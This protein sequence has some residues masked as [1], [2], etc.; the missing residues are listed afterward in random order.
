MENVKNWFSNPELIMTFVIKYGGQ[1]LFAIITLIIGLWIISLLMKGMK[2]MFIARDVE[3]GLQSFLLSVS[4]I[5][6][7]IM[8]FISVISMLGIRMTS[9]IAVLGAAGLAIGMALSGSLQN[10][11]GGVMILIFKPFKVGDYITAQ[12]ESGTVKEIQIFHT[13]LNSPDKK[14]IILPNG[15]L[16]TGSLTNYSTEPQR[17]VDF[18]FGIGYGDEIDKAKE[19]IMGIIN[20]DE[21]ILKEPE[22]FIGVINLGNSSVDLVVRVWANAADYWGIFFDMQETVKKEFDKQGISIPF[23]QQ[24][25]HLYQTRQ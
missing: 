24:D 11:A 7:K 8:L 9:F 6:L 4:R 17:R 22:P 18:T 13:I 2:K 12:G 23:P 15:A 20:R 25:V 14:T 3:P 16:S 5:A 1:L 21:R 19:V 10:F